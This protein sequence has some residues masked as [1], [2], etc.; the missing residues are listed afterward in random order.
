[1]YYDVDDGVSAARLNFSL[2]LCP[3][4]LYGEYL[5]PE[6]P[7]QQL[8]RSH[9]TIA[10]CRGQMLPLCIADLTE[11]MAAS[12]CLLDDQACSTTLL[13]EELHEAKILSAEPARFSDADTRASR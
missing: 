4:V 6:R 3:W 2:S 1:M 11:V 10:Q 13:R 8:R 12:L 5:L 9:R 7:S